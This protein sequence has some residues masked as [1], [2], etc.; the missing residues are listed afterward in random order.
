MPSRIRGF[1]TLLSA[2]IVLLTSC[3]SAPSATS[4][5]VTLEVL[6]SNCAACPVGSLVAREL[7][8]TVEGDKVVTTDDEGEVATGMRD[9]DTVILIGGD[10]TTDDSFTVRRELDFDGGTFSG[11]S[12]YTYSSGCTV[13]WSNESVLKNGKA[14]GIH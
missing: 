12:I 5:E 7:A 10:T 11:R 8:F 13:T 4:M 2:F 6:E 1:G 9:G 14:I 3:A